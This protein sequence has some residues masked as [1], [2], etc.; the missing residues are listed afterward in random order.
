MFILFIGDARVTKTLHHT[1]Q[2]KQVRRL[3]MC[4]SSRQG[5]KSIGRACVCPARRQRFELA[6]LA[7]EEHPVLAP[8]LAHC[9]QLK[10]APKQR[11]EWMGDFED[12]RFTN[13]MG[14]S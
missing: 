14:C 3:E 9:Q 4:P 6:L 12:L 2:R 13:T 10:A 1:D 7:V 11:V 5:D 8:G